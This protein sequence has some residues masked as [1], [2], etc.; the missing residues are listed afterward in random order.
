MA[1]T[2]L[3]R[4]HLSADALVARVRSSFANVADPRPGRPAIPLA[5]ALMSAFA[6]FALKDPSLLAFD[7]RRHDDNL[8]SLYRIGRVPSDTQMRAILDQVPPE[9][10][11]PSYQDVFRQLQRGKVLEPYVY[12]QGC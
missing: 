8:R 1:G 6:M 2:L 11:R 10:L 5:D 12:L 4:K 7:Q 9:D 3:A